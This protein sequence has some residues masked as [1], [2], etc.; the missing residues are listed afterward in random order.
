MLTTLLLRKA[1][2]NMYFVPRSGSKYC[3][4]NNTKQNVNIYNFELKHYCNR[5]RYIIPHCKKKTVLFMLGGSLGFLN[6]P[7]Y[8]RIL[9]RCCKQDYSKHFNGLFIF[10]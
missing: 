9:D 5:A 10:Y 2:W 1:K 6:I 3:F 8:Y 7:T 4:V